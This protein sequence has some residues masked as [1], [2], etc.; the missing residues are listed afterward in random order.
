MKEKFKQNFIITLFM[1]LSFFYF[2]SM[3][4][5]IGDENTDAPGDNGSCATGCHYKSDGTGTVALMDVPLFYEPGETYN[6][7][8]VIH[9]T[10]ETEFGLRRAGFQIVATDGTN[11]IQLGEFTDTG[12]TRITSNNR[13]ADSPHKTFTGDAVSWDIIWTAPSGEV[14]DNIVFY[15]AAISGDGD[16]L[17]DR[18]PIGLD[19][20][21]R[22]QN[23]TMLMITLAVEF[24]SFDAYLNAKNQVT[25]N[26]EINSAFHHEGFHIQRTKDLNKDFSTI[27]WV[28]AQDDIAKNKLYEFEDTQVVAGQTYYY[29]LQEKDRNGKRTTSEVVAVFVEN[30]EEIL[31]YPNP[32]EEILWIKMPTNDLVDRKIKVVD[33]LGQVVKE[34]ALTNVVNS[35]IAIDVSFY[36]KGIYLIQVFDNH[37]LSYQGQFMKAGY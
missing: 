3:S 16:G 32:V 22:G 6:M 18:D 23:S 14:P 21:Y 10:D 13:I 20:E 36:P 30:E 8:L 15:Y 9:D 28:D 24:L 27:A 33:I 31:I 35:P 2:S 5:F 37:K 1:V 12:D 17:K 29:R 11:N 25:L 4:N 26:W 19:S 7:N 34:E